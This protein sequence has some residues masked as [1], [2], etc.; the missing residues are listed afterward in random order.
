MA[1]NM[2]SKRWAINGLLILL[3]CLAAYF[4]N[5]YHALTLQQPENK[6]SDL[7][8]QD[9]H[10][11]IIE[12]ADNK[13]TLRNKGN[14]WVFEAPVQWPA[15]N[16]TIE[17]L[18]SIVTS[19]SIFRL[20][21]QGTDL[22]TLGL[23]YPK[24]TLT[25]NNTPILFG[26]TNNIGERR[27]VMI[28]P[29]VYLLP[30]LHLH[31]MTRGIA[32]LIDHRLLPRSVKLKSLELNGL[33]LSKNSNGVWQDSEVE[34]TE[35]DQ[36]S[37]LANNWQTLSAGQVKAF[38]K[39]TTPDQ[40]IV[41]TLDDGNKIIFSLMSVKPE[42]IIARPELGVQYHFLEKQYNDLLSIARNEP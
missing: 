40:N 9:I 13:I 7:R 15:D 25:L 35:T 12:T 6:I 8:P 21:A 5:R 36:F 26:A 3:I 23:Q 31:F 27:Y 42:I 17:R 37:L 29:A 19:E 22:P 4:G 16:L 1:I 14:Q 18:I 11:A 41:A 34:D 38:D 24:A 32:G 20:S 10:T 30:D 2:L 28:D 39:S 33:S